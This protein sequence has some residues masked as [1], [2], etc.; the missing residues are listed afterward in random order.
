MKKNEMLE[1]MEISEM[2][3]VEA[4]WN[5]LAGKD[6]NATKLLNKIRTSKRL[7]NIMEIDKK[8]K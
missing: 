3:L 4:V 6:P 1:I 5:V 7:K 2:E 8:E